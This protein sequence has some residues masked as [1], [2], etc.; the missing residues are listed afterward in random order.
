M[1]IHLVIHVSNLKPYHWDAIDMQRNF[2]ARPT[3]N[4]SQKEDKNVEEILAEWIRKGQRPTR[5]IHK[6]LVKWKN[7][8]VEETSWECVEDIKA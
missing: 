2:I 3:I 4:L 7:L 6:Y 5:R 1:E 8:P